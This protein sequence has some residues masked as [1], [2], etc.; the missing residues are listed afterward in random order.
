MLPKVGFI[1]SWLRVGM[2]TASFLV[3]AS[4]IF[5]L[6]QTKTA[7]YCCEQSSVAAAISNLKYGTQ[8]G[9]LYSGVFDY[10]IQHY[11]EPLEQA[12]TETQSPDIG[13]PATPPGEVYKTTRDGNGI[14]YPLI[15]TAAFRLF[16][17][18]TWALTLIML[19][20]MASSAAALLTRFSGTIFAAI[21]ALYF[22]ALTVML[23]GPIIWDPIISPQIAV[24]GIRYFS[25]VCALPL[26]HILFELLGQPVTQPRNVGRNTA[27]LALQT[28]IF[29]IA[30]L[31]RGS[32]L[33]LV[34]AIMFMWLLL[35]R[36]NQRRAARRRA[37]FASAAVMALT[38]VSIL[39][40]IALSTPRTYLTEGRFGTVIWQRVTESIGAMNPKWPFP[41]VNALF[42]C[43]DYLPNGLLRGGDDNNGICIWFDY[44]AKHHIPFDTISDKTFGT[45]YETALRE[46]FFK[47]AAHYPGEVLKTFFYY[48]P[49]N[50]TPSLFFDLRF[51]LYGDQSKAFVPTGALVMPYPPLAIALLL[52]SLTIAL[53][54]FII[55][56]VTIA[57]LGR[58]AYVTL[59]SALFTL[60]AYLAAWA[61]PHTVG[62]LLLYCLIALGLVVG[63]LLAFVRSAFLFRHRQ[64]IRDQLVA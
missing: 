13:L 16:G 18:H 29:V 27:L 9:S 42:Q 64:A 20:L 33:S 63:T 43:H 52:A 2:V 21:V 46:G 62:D 25:L 40:G 6:P 28:A 3:Y 5:L 41:G 60:P 32:A 55:G 17:M 34:G 38:T 24:G 11:K 45:L 8:L 7:Y 4:I 22:S 37:L 50:I 48:K 49:L 35:I 54:S 23:F 58:T 53:G 19:I 26:L 47:I 59:L 61:L 57:E 10:L 44:V 51:N 56:P 15:A 14:G 36:W 30:I 31:V 39:A 1:C 12:L